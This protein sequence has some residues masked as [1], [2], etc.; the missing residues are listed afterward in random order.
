MI[1]A[2]AFITFDS[3]T[4]IDIC[5]RTILYNVLIFQST[6]RLCKFRTNEALPVKYSASGACCK[7]GR[8]ISSEE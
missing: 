7:G 5:V 2:E 6:R 3:L 8:D 1:R 4:T